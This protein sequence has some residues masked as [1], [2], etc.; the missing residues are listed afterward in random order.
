VSANTLFNKALMG[1]RLLRSCKEQVLRRKNGRLELAV[2]ASLALH[3]LVLALSS[4]TSGG[5]VAGARQ[6][7][8]RI[9]N[10]MLL[11]APSPNA[12]R[13]VPEAQREE[14]ITPEPPPSPRTDVD[15]RLDISNPVSPSVPAAIAPR[16][17]DSASLPQPATARDVSESRGG[18]GLGKLPRL[19]SEIVLDYPASA[20]D[21]EGKVTLRIVVSATG[22]VDEVGVINSDPPGVFDDAAIRAFSPARFSPGEMLGVP[23]KASIVIE[24]NFLPTSR[25]N[26]S[27]RGY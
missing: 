19:I 13:P 15:V 16:E 12:L 11:P 21:R 10:A 8:S 17:A 20:G 3:L 18:L 26:V 1:F 24:V 9:L 4:P 14:A 7:D 23:V 5:N 6:L 27:G 25:G 2:S 22:S